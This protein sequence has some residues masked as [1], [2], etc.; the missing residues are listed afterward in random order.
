MRAVGVSESEAFR[1]LLKYVTKKS[2]TDHFYYPFAEHP[3]FK[4][5]AY[6]RIRRHRSMD[7]ST[8]YLNQ[9]PREANMTIDELKRIIQE[10]DPAVFMR[11]ITA[12]SANI[13]GI[14]YF[15]FIVN[16]FSIKIILH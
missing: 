12:Y 9:N 6:D 8:I 10:G 16:D 13:T 14:F 7:Q 11:K 5:W 15:I 3:R 2:N 1:H 4:F